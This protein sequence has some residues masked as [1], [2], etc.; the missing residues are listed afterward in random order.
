MSNMSEKLSSL[1]ALYRSHRWR[2]RLI[3]ATLITVI[4]LVVIRISMPYTIVY[5]AV[6]W[7]GQQ[8]IASQIE[9]IQINVTE[10]TFAIINATGSKNGNT[11]FNIGKA[12][13]DWQWRP[14]AS[15]NVHIKEILL[16]DFDMQATQ[17]ADAMVI[18]GVTIRQDGSVE[19]PPPAAEEQT[20]AWSAGLDRIDLKD[21]AFCYQQF[22]NAIDDAQKSKRI[23]YCGNIGLISWQG[24]FGLRETEE[25]ATPADRLYAAGT[26]RIEQLN[27]L[28]NLL[29]NS[30]INI[31][32]LSLT[33]IDIDGINDIKLDAVTVGQLSLLQGSGHVRHEHA[34]EFDKLDIS[35]VKVG[36][37]QA[38]EIE[39]ITLVKPVVS[40]AREKSGAWTY[41]EW[42]PPQAGADTA[43]AAD[44]EPEQ[45]EQ[46]A[47][48][49]KL[50]NITITDAEACLQQPK[51]ADKHKTEAIDYCV[52]LANTSWKGSMDITPPSGDQPIGLGVNGDLGLAQFKAHNNVL[53]RDLLAFA[54]LAI[55]GVQ[56]RG[57]ED[58]AFKTLDF[59]DVTGLE[60]TTDEDKHTVS[61]SSVDV[62]AFSYRQNAV[63][64]DKLAI[65]DLG[66]DITLDPDGTMDFEHWKIQAADEAATADETTS[67]EPQAEQS[68]AEPLKL[69]LGEFSLDSTRMI[70]FTDMTVKPA[71]EIGFSELHASISNLD[72]DKPEQKSPLELKAKTTRRGT[73]EIKGVAMPFDSK[74]SFDATGKLVGIDLRVASPKAEQAIGHIIKSGQLDAD[75]TLLSEKGQLD[76]NIGL[77]L[78]HFNLKAKSKEDA[79]A[80]DE[81]FGMPI[82]QSLVLLKDKKN[83][84]KLDIPITGDVN[85]PSF[86]PTDAIIKATTKA[87][88]VTLITFYTPYGL[89]FAGGNVLFDLATALNFDPLVFEPGSAQLNDAHEEQL[90]N[91]AKLLAE[92]PQVHLTLCGFT[93]L[94]DRDKMFSEIIDPKKIKPASPENL[95]KLKQLG[96]ERQEAVKNH[97]IDIGKIEH[98]RLIL[99][100]PEHSD[101]A[102][103]LAGV[104]ISI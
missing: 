68:S 98:N 14:L 62:T 6:Y 45:T 78:H 99:C 100:E 9:D 7:L 102:E 81:T 11:V 16:E 93:N 48:N 20:V 71:M 86:N 51:L 34:V 74:P 69:K 70:Q 87:T 22:E 59:D 104:E 72:S 35:G 49:L 84:I 32:E 89:A 44:S 21:L 2:G 15:K 55:N 30:L 103:A 40:A 26:F 83:R 46:K 96:N 29:E 95:T 65:N 47:L 27:L 64:I 3:L 36:D 38:F 23:D 73:I 80:L 1:R 63:A 31:A 66:V 85:D 101:D 19:P 94:K 75:L 33:E 28:N 53:K 60:L 42:L 54:K 50:G 56:V 25:T 67:A 92:R 88:T 12:S 18:A 24:E 17:Y 76:S 41:Q 8:G 90:A 39:S 61:V 5:S 13:I 43:K 97:L 10:G 52:T 79:A 4:V 82:N 37:I 57:T 58:V 77:V 91:L